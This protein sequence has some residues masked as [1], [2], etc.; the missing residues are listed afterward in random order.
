MGDIMHNQERMKLIYT[1]IDDARDSF[2]KLYDKVASQNLGDVLV[3]VAE[4]RIRE[5]FYKEVI[6]IAEMHF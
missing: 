6:K 1:A 3:A 5:N 4:N 2:D